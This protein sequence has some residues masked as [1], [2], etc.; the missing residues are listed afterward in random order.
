MSYIYGAAIQGIQSFIFETNELKD[1]VGASEIVEQICTEGYLDFIEPNQVGKIIAAAG[2]IK[3]YAENKD[4]FKELVLK[5]PKYV[6]EEAPGITISQSVIEVKGEPTKSDFNRLEKNLKAQRNKPIPPAFIT[7][8]GIERSRRTGKSAVDRDNKGLRDLSSKIKS[9]KSQDNMKPSNE[10][11]A[12]N[13]LQKKLLGDDNKEKAPFPFDLSDMT[14]HKKS[15]WIAVIH[16]DGNNL[17]KVIQSLSADNG[18]KDTYE[19]FS[20]A[21]DTATCN[22]AQKAFD[23]VI[24]PKKGKKFYPIR[25]IVL[26]GDDLTVICRA[27]LAIDFTSSFLRFFEEETAGKKDIKK[28]TACAGIAFVKEKYPFHY[29]IDL[30]EQLCGYAKKISKKNIKNNADVPASIMFHKIQSGFVDQF[31]DIKERELKAKKSEIDFCY[32]PYAISE[33]EYEL[34]TIDKLM[35]F[36]EKCKDEKF[37]TSGL[38]KL[39]TEL[40]KDKN[41]AERLWD[42]ILQ[43]NKDY[44]KVLE[45]NFSFK[46]KKTIIYDALSILSLTKGGNNA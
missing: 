14:N 25:P 7:A 26:G 19:K 24:K 32:G 10:N 44:K 28:L 2:N 22:A 40:H 34:P 39:L 30:A 36:V 21:L 8:L 42:R 17:G 46:K 13:R 45:A 37:P 12:Y 23:A 35:D 3:L 41:N 43:I 38:R 31:N 1:I 4:D 9:E 29:A 20:T 16:A 11:T 6:Q 27:D 33:N 15:N 5:F 18:V